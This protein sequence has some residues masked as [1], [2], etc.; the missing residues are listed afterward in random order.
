MSLEPCVAWI[1]ADREWKLGG[2]SCAPRVRNVVI[3]NPK[4]VRII[5]YNL[6]VTSINKASGAKKAA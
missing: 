3:A 2:G 1:D 5:A 4:Q 6:A